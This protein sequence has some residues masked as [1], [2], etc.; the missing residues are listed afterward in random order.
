M[1]KTYSWREVVHRF[2]SII[3]EPAPEVEPVTTAQV[4]SMSAQ[5][6]F[7]ALRLVAGI[8]P[9]IVGWAAGR[10][11][12]ARQVLRDNGIEAPPPDLDNDTLP[13]GRF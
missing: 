1:G 6:V 9:G 13:P 12:E 5:V 3:A 4:Q 11:E 8:R 2:A 10:E 7:Q